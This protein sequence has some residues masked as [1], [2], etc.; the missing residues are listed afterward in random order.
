MQDLNQL[1]PA[2]LALLDQWL[3]LGV[4]YLSGA[5][6]P[7][8]LLGYLPPLL[9]ALL[10][11]QALHALMALLV[12]LVSF[13]AFRLDAP[14][15]ALVLYVASYV[16]AL[17]GFVARAQRRRADYAAAELAQ[18]RLEVIT[19]LDALDRRSRDADRPRPVPVEPQ[20]LRERE[21]A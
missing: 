19:F 13:A 11:R 15:L 21:P 18:L 8:G 10:S 5:A 9:L 3:A 6:G 4:H 2:W 16:V 17:H 12:A 14:A 1:F 7:I 20:K